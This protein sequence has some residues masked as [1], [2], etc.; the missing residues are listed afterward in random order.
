M[1]RASSSSW[2]TS[3]SRRCASSGTRSVSPMCSSRSAENNSRASWQFMARGTPN[4]DADSF[5]LQ[6]ERDREL[7]P[8]EEHLLGEYLDLR[9]MRGG[10]RVLGE[11]D[12]DRLLGRILLRVPVLLELAVLLPA[13]EKDPDDVHVE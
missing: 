1:R 13:A 8:R 7:E 12:Q 9:V 5:E 6:R 4:L 3:H 11:R 2:Q 10:D